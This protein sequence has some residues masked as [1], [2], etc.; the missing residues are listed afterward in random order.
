M[1]RQIFVLITTE[2]QTDLRFLDNI[3][4]SAFE[5]VAYECE[6][7]LSISTFIFGTKDK[8]ASFADYV[9]RKAREAI[10]QGA[11]TIAV[12][13]DADKNS[14]DERLEYN[15]LP[16]FK[17]LENLGE[18]E[19]CKL[20][21]PII[22]VRMTEAW[23]LADTELLKQEL[24]TELSDAELGLDGDPEKM[25]NPKERIVSAIKTAK[26]HSRHKS[27]VKDVDISELYEILGQ[28]LSIDKLSKLYSYR[29]FL[30]EIR[31][32]YKSLGLLF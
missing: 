9:E 8:E 14:Y 16:V 13:S 5:A 31:S 26:E 29:R 21:T 19:C 18:D 3:V 32:T 20:I 28:K 10:T 7:E 4:K 12:H 25:A 23:M 6:K 15:F 27:P 1:T 11:T 24:G 2:G 30:D 22:P 17:K